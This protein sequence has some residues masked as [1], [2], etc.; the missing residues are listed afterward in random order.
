MSTQPSRQLARRPRQRRNNPDASF[1]TAAVL[2]HLCRQPWLVSGRD[3]AAIGAV[4]RN[5]DDVRDAVGKLGWVVIADR[6]FVRLR[7]SPPP[8][9]QAWVSSGPKPLTAMW[10]FLLVAAAES[11]PP[12]VALGQLVTGARAAA[13]EA[14]LHA[15]DDKAEKHAIL[16]ALRMLQ[17]RAVVET[18]DGDIDEFLIDADAPVLLAVHHHRLVH[19]IANYCAED[20]VAHPELWLEAV[21]R[22]SDPARRMRRRLIDDTAVHA[23]DLA[24]DE[25]DWLSRRVRSDDGL[26]LATTFGLHLERRAEGAAFIVPEDAFSTRSEL[27]DR[28]FPAGGTVP[29]AALLLCDAATASGEISIDRP[30]WK[31]LMIEEIMRLLAQFAAVFVGH[32]WSTDYG[33]DLPVLASDV[34]TLLDGLGLLLIDARQWSFSPVTARWSPPPPRPLPT[35]RPSTNAQPTEAT[36][37]EPQP[38]TTFDLFNN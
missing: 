21:D 26:P 18:L 35:A 19:V 8:R 4:L 31:S 1:E 27:G 6:D 16:A 23:I 12:K 9:R 32:G 10:F 11:M 22:E 2:R 5:L 25:A 33:D 28:P 38:T 7:K 17:D 36:E 20:P 15:P 14:E 24:A 37:A 13:A 34:S 29:H 3:D 30:G